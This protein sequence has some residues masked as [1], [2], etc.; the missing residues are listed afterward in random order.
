MRRTEEE[1]VGLREVLSQVLEIKGVTS[2]AVVNHE[3]LIVESVSDGKVDLGFASGLIASSLASSQVLAGLMGEG[4]LQQ[5]MIEYD[6]GPIL[7]TP[8]QRADE[9]A[10]DYVAVVTLSSTAFLGRAKFQLRKLLPKVS[11]AVLV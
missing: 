10:S 3:G 6:K 4:K 1:R 2:A 8:L 5:A 11:E 7:I 9:A